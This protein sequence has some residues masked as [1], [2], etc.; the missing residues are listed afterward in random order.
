[1]NSGLIAHRYAGAFLEFLDGKGRAE[2]VYD[3]VRVI[4]SAMGKLPKFRIA[5][6]DPRS[7][8]LGRRKELLAAAVAPE[9]LCPEIADFLVLMDRNGRSEFFRLALL[10]FLTMYR[11]SRNLVMVQLTSAQKDERLV[12]VITKLVEEDFGKKAVIHQKVD[13]D[14][15]GG[16]VFETWSYRLDA[17]VRTALEKVRE[18]LKE[19][20][21]RL[22]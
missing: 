11:H 8:A 4:L 19:E 1:M 5:I 13:P 16:F 12:P 9:P 15:I 2:V 14:I 7:V 10:D 18:E 21:R 3:Q 6:T 22:V 17:S 20:N